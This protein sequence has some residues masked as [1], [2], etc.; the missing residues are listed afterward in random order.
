MKIL[1]LLPI[2]MILSACGNPDIRIKRQVD[3]NEIIGTWQLDAKSSALA[4]DHDGDS[5][6][7]N[8]AN[9]HEIRFNPDGTC[10]YR[11]VLQMP[12]RF[13]DAIGNWSIEPTHDDVRGCMIAIQL[14]TDEGETHTFNLDIKEEAGALVIWEFWSDPDLW[15]FL[16]YRRNQ[17]KQNAR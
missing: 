9:P 8:T 5:Y 1:M 2:A 11:S 16:E 12:T 6:E 13:I 10:R 17:A 14:R 3:K 15:N 7:M 4:M